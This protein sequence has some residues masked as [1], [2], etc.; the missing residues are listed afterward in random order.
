MFTSKFV[1]ICT[2]FHDTTGSAIPTGVQLASIPNTL[3]TRGIIG[4]GGVTLAACAPN[5]LTALHQSLVSQRLIADEM[6]RMLGTIYENILSTY[7]GAP[8]QTKDSSDLALVS[9][10]H[11]IYTS[12]K[13]ASRTAE[14]ANHKYDD[15]RAKN[16]DRNRCTCSNKRPPADVRKPNG[17]N[18]DWKWREHHGHWDTH[19]I[20]E[21]SGNRDL[22]G[23]DR[24]CGDPSIQT[25]DIAL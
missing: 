23:P 8:T 22:P 6:L 5:T 13:G 17:G 19:S 9:S 7:P 11:D 4:A 2:D 1:A 3:S 21:H 16:T 24:N 25:R 15:G 10:G 18:G 20:G 14:H 12:C